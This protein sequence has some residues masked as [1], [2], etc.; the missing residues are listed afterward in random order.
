MCPQANAPRLSLLRR[1][2][3]GHGPRA[4]Q[5]WLALRSPTTQ[6][7][8]NMADLSGENLKRSD[9]LPEVLGVCY[10]RA[11]KDSWFYQREVVF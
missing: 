7:V 3:T 8:Y 1:A 5:V 2:S 6:P 9:M 11:S 4:V 10:D